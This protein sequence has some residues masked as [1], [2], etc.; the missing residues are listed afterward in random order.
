MDLTD[1]CRTFHPKAKEYT[2][3]SEPHSNFS[4]IDHMDTKQASTDT[5]RL[6]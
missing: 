2:F 4:K 1:I 3:L 6:K 5:R